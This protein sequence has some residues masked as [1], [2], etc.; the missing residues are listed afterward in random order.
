MSRAISVPHGLPVE[1]DAGPFAPPSRLTRLREERPVSPMVFP[2]GHEGWIVTG[3][4]AVRQVLADTRFSSR[5]DLDITHVPYATSDPT[6][7]SEPSPQVPGM[8]VTMDPPE[9]TRLRGRLTGAFTAKRMKQLAERISELVERQLDELARLSPPVDLFGEFALPVPSLVICELLGVPYADRENFQGNS[10]TFLARDISLDEKFAAYGA[11]TEYLSELI[12]SKRAD[13][14][15]DVLSELAQHDDL[16][17]EELTGAAVLL[18]LAG[19]ETTADVL[20]MGTFALLEHPAQLAELRADPELMP[21]AVE[22]LM[23]YLSVVDSVQRYATEDADVG[24]ETIGEGSTVVLSLLAANHD[25]RRFDDPDVLEIHREARGHLNLGH[26]IH[27]C[28]GGQLARIELR[29]GF[30][31]LL[32]RFPNLELAVPADEVRL[33]TDA[34]IYG[35]RELPVT[36]G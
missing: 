14:G 24:G 23:R 1:R 16:T 27:Q 35:V 25:P 4:E 34:N 36:W 12:T 13:P 7:P 3:Y 28:L 18:L 2:D 30:A 33:K 15:A 8:F 22:E 32:R 10:A 31:G 19:H 6:P 21:G 29:A 20:A 9:H 5:Q 11:M 17:V 26:G